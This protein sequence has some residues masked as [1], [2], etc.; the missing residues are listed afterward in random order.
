ML[1]I[2]AWHRPAYFEECLASWGQARGVRKLRRV[3]VRLGRS[4]A[5]VE[6]AMRAVARSAAEE[7]HVPFRIVLDDPEDALAKG[8]DRPLG[9]EIN[10]SFDDPGCEFVIACDEDVK[11]SDDI[12]EYYARMREVAPDLDCVCAHND[13]GQGWSPVWDD[14]DADQ[15]AVRVRGEF[16]SWCFGV[17]RRAWQDIWLPEWDWNRSAGPYPEWGW[18]WQMHRQANAGLRVAIPDASRCLHIGEH[19]GTF[20]LPHRFAATQAQSFR[21]HREPVQYQ[22]ADSSD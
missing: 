14:A 8:Q 7:Y 20:L 15:A 1:V 13:L 3:T 6:A 4:D 18:E 21:K 5:A 16:T 9:S 10:A 11:V 17:S 19:D 2:P 12:L 22:L